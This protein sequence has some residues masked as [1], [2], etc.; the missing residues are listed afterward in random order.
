MLS[1][2]F[3]TYLRIQMSNSPRHV[4]ANCYIWVLWHTKKFVDFPIQWLT[5]F[6][7]NKHNEISLHF[8]IFLN[9]VPV[10]TEKLNNEF[11]IA[12]DKFQHK[13]FALSLTKTV[14]IRYTAVEIFSILWRHLRKNDKMRKLWMSQPGRISKVMCPIAV[15]WIWALNRM[16]FATCRTE[17]VSF[18]SMDLYFSVL[19]KYTNFHVSLKMVELWP[20]LT[21]NES[22]FQKSPLTCCNKK[23]Q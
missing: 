17:I 14:T 8:L 20:L 13:H 3:T 11:K 21:E 23:I 12:S 2:A 10:I 22:T 4:H 19:S 5:F 7:V 6:F 15:K 16:Y 1:L 18:W 9:F